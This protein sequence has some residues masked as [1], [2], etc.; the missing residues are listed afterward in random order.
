MFLLA[1]FAQWFTAVPCNSFL[2]ALTCFLL[3][4]CVLLQMSAAINQMLGTPTGPALGNSGSASLE[5]LLNS[6]T[7]GM[8]L[9]PPGS[10][11]NI[12]GPPGAPDGT[13]AEGGQPPGSSSGLGM[14]P[15]QGGAAAG[16]SWGP[17]GSRPPPFQGS[18]L[19]MLGGAGPNE[20]A[21]FGARGGDEPG[22]LQLGP[23][24]PLCHI[25]DGSC[26]TG[27]LNDAVAAMAAAATSLQ[28]VLPVG[29][30]MCGAGVLLM[31]Q[32]TVDACVKL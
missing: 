24:A 8:S 32:A 16:P 9:V 2:S 23:V 27:P 28:D 17:L 29:A 1:T 4:T 3:H 10:Q 15:G 30:G 25:P 18:G 6:L 22:R 21:G 5:A 19:S 13:G 14:G 7:T 20:M 12:P 11:S 26:L 31:K